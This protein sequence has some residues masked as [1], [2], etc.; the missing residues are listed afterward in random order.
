M[1]IGLSADRVALSA[2]QE[3]VDVGSMNFQVTG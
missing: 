3:S 2:Q 1:C